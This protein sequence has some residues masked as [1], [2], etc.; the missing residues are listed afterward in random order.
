[1]AVVIEKD[2]EPTHTIEIH[3]PRLRIVCDQSEKLD[4]LDHFNS[5]RN[6]R[7]F[8]SN[9]MASSTCVGIAT[10]MSRGTG[11]GQN[12]RPC[13]AL[14]AGNQ[15]VCKL[16]DAVRFWPRSRVP[17]AA[18]PGIA[19]WRT[20][21][22]RQTRVLLTSQRGGE[23]ELSDADGDTDDDD[24]EEPAEE[25]RLDRGHC[26]ASVML[27]DLGSSVSVH[28]DVRFAA[29]RRCKEHRLIGRSQFTHTCRGSDLKGSEEQGRP[30]GLLVS[31]VR[32]MDTFTTQDEHVSPLA[33]FVMEFVATVFG[34]GRC[35]RTC[36]RIRA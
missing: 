28:K 12:Q 36:V 2:D 26:V 1:M 7:N 22:T 33:A 25:A 8:T 27:D 23:P 16:G 19:I 32:A 3:G 34:L 6:T 29:F 20:T 17:R 11:C 10:G 21:C 5:R 9:S 13:Q 14:I 4:V 15:Y 24:T 35:C 31:Q 30:I 18:P